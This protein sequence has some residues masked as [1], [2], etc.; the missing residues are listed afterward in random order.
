MTQYFHIHPENPQARLIKQAC[1]LF[2][3]AALLLIPQTQPTP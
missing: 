2:V 3:M 1:R